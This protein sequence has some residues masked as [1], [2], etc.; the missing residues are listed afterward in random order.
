M[1][2][3][4]PKPSTEPSSEPGEPSGSSSE[5]SSPR[6]EI[7]GRVERRRKD[8]SFSQPS[9]LR[10]RPSGRGAS[11]S[12]PPT[13]ITR[14]AS[15]TRLD[16]PNSRS[17]APGKEAQATAFDA[18]DASD[19]EAIAALLEGLRELARKAE[20]GRAAGHRAEEAAAEARAALA[21]AEV[22]LI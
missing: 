3:A 20:V 5:P 14:A 15:G 10:S 11:Y 8:P 12:K 22:I 7:R 21:E 18:S 19:G 6:S 4:E 1:E 16:Q 13:G 2:I 9:K 17:A